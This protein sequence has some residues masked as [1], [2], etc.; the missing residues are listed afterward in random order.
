MGADTIAGRFAILT[1]R[2]HAACARAGREPEDVRL[3]AV[4]KTYGPEIIREA[5]DAGIQVFGE[6]RVQE[7]AAKIELAPPGL[8]WHLVGHLQSNKA[9]LAVRLFDLV[10]SVD[11]RRLLQA[12]DR[13]AQEEGRTLPVLLQVNVSGEASKF[14]LAH[15]EVPGLLEAAQECM[16]LEVRGVMTIPPFTPEP[17][18]A[19]PVFA[20]LRACRDAWR[21]ASGFDLPELSMGMSHDFEVA[22]AEG[23]T[24]IRVGS[25]LFGPRGGA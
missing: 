5:A 10:H 22:I 25:A 9:R 1:E 3:I 13:M 19:A 16:N 12:L 2:V 21:A 8:E 20:R 14:G 23:A 6:N 24:M 7:A 18:K 17:E 4:S 11:S 15:D